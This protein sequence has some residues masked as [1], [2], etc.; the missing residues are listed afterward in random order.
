MPTINNPDGTYMDVDDEH[1]GLMFATIETVDAHVNKT[2]GKVWSI[3]FDAL[4]PT[5]I[6]DFVLYIK[7]T[8]DKVLLISDSRITSK[9]AATELE[10]HGVSGTAA[11]GT[12]TAPFSRTIGGAATVTGII[13]SGA[14]ITGLTAD[15]TIFYQQ[16]DTIGKESH[17]STSSKI[18]IPKGKAVALSVKVATASLTGIVSIIE[19]E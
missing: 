12:T 16:C 7:N 11:G 3:A 1:R 15:G 19:E 2:N 6:D 10:W 18:R 5:A 17:L 14:D 4:S 8:G 9:V 13:E